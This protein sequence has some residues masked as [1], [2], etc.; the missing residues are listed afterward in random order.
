MV[1][2]KDLLAILHDI[3]ELQVLAYDNYQLQHGGYLEKKYAKRLSGIT[4]G[5]LAG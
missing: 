5:E 2:L 3:T 4:E 1:I